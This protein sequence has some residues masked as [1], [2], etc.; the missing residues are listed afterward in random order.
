MP[1]EDLIAWA[2]ADLQP[3]AFKI[4]CLYRICGMNYD[5]LLLYMSRNTVAKHFIDVLAFCKKEAEALS[6]LDSAN[7]TEVK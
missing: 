7:S 5:D 4:W 3:S 6:K 2:A 1:I